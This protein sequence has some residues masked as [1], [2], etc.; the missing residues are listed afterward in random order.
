MSKKV[1]AK[2]KRSF[3]KTGKAISQSVGSTKSRQKKIIQHREKA[4]KS[5]ERRRVAA[6][7]T[8]GIK[9]EPR[10]IKKTKFPKK[11]EPSVIVIKE[12]QK[13]YF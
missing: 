5:A 7:E 11:R 4:F 1:G 3:R 9:V 12:K 6:F 10:K 2:L 13:S 8:I